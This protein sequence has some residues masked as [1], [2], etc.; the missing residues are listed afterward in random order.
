[1]IIM[2]GP[3]GSGN[4]LFSKALNINTHIHGWD[5]LMDTYWEGHDKEPFAEHWKNP[6]LLGTIPHENKTYVTSISAPYFDNGVEQIPYYA[7]F[8]REA[9]RLHWQVKV[10]IVGR[11][12]NILQCQQERVRDRHTTPDFLENMDYLL[13]YNPLFVSQELLYLYKVDYLNMIE[14]WIGNVAWTIDKTAL[15]EILKE[16]ANKKYIQPIESNWLDEHI[17][18]ASSKH[19]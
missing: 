2:T 5:S 1:M 13:N 8:I 18:V 15:D 7:S 19:D 4:H 16:D 11:D 17:K 6:S 14:R 9:I 10:I 3:Q 12:Q